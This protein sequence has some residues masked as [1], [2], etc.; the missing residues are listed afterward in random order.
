MVEYLVCTEETR[1][2]FTEG[3][4]ILNGFLIKQDKIIPETYRISPIARGKPQLEFE[5]ARHPTGSFMINGISY[6]PEWPRWTGNSSEQDLENAL[7][8]AV[9]IANENYEGTEKSPKR[10]TAEQ[11]AEGIRVVMFD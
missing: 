7:G 10:V 6:R 3:P 8:L 1:V 9:R 2:R 11:H 4:F 5:L